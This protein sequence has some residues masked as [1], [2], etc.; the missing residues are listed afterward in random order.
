M[1]STDPGNPTLDRIF[2]LSIPEVEK[3]FLT[4]D[5]RKCTLTAY[6]EEKA[7]DPFGLFV[8][9]LRTPGDN[10]NYAAYIG[11]DSSIE[12]GGELISEDL[13]AVRPAMWINLD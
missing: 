4:N 13:S 12:Y 1:Y 9:W 10:Q 7:L 5:D 6:A 8:W 2:L 11:E 3:Y